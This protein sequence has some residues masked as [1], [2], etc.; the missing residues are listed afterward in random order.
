MT[1]TCRVPHGD[2]P[3]MWMFTNCVWGSRRPSL[4]F[5]HPVWSNCTSQNAMGA[6]TGVFHIHVLHEE[7]HSGGFFYGLFLSL[8][9]KNMWKP[10][11]LPYFPDYKAQCFYLIVV[12]F[13]KQAGTLPQLL[14]MI[15][16]TMLNNSQNSNTNGKSTQIHQQEAPKPQF[17]GKRFNK[18]EVEF[19]ILAVFLDLNSYS[20][21]IF[22]PKQTKGGEWL[23]V[24]KMRCLYT[25]MH[26]DSETSSLCDGDIKGLK[27]SSPGILEA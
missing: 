14:L 4:R 2:H 9:T 25:D 26:T 17:R 20:I 3:D 10:C 21:Y 6:N 12:R 19:I 11:Y 5:P 22:P 27:S 7:I 23:R 18:K 1:R 16:L 8:K 15:I 24:W 13:Q